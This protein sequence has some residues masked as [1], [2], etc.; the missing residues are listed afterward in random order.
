MVLRR[1]ALAFRRQDWFAV[2]VELL[3]VVFGVAIAFQVSDWGNERAARAEEQQLLRGLDAEF[4]E[5][6]ASIDA[7]IAKHRRVEEAVVATLESLERAKASGAATASIPD[8]T[9]AW[10]LVSTTTQF[11][12]GILRGMLVTGRLGLIRDVEL[13]TALSEWDGVLVDVTE[14]EVNSRSIQIEQVEPTLRS[15]MDVSGF[16]RYA[17][18]FDAPSELLPE[19]SSAVPVDDETIGAFATRLFWQQHVIREFEGPKAE[20]RRIAGLIEQSLER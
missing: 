4:A 12:Q 19:S 20:A 13:R 11:G 2:A 18:L 16:R 10:S 14:D 1:L 17:L 5:V 9:L 7:Q 15:R 3:V 8:R 6:A